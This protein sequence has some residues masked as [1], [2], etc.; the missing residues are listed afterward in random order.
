MTIL[1]GCSV[2]LGVSEESALGCFGGSICM[3]LEIKGFVGLVA[4]FFVTIS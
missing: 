2:G 4:V 3:G 1:F